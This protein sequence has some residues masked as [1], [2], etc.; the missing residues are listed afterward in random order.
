MVSPVLR[1]WIFSYLKGSPTWGSY[2]NCLKEILPKGALTWRELLRN[3]SF[4]L[5]GAL[6]WKELLTEGALNWK[7]LLPEGSSPEGSSYPNGA[8]TWREL[9]PELLEGNTYLKGTLTK[10]KRELTWRELLPERSSYLK[11][12]LT[13]KE[14]LP[15]GNSYQ[16]GTPT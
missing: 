13:R 8:L 4:Y 12:A 15:E 16:K 10:R 5:K 14:L 1:I 7:E 6:T 9:L 11:G 3:R 2:I